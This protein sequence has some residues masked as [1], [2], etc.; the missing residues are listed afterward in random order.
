MY[1]RYHKHLVVGNP[2][3]LLAKEMAI[4]SSGCLGGHRGLR[5]VVKAAINRMAL[6]MNGIPETSAMGMI[7]AG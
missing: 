4:R 2:N 5:V 6:E 3:L 7:C 1:R